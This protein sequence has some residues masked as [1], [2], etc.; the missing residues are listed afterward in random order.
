MG[1]YRPATN[2][3]TLPLLSEISQL[4]C[5]ETNCNISICT[6]SWLQPAAQSH[7]CTQLHIAII[8]LLHVLSHVKVECSLGKVIDMCYEVID[9]LLTNTRIHI[10]P[11]NIPWY[12]FSWLFIIVCTDALVESTPRQFGWKYHHN[13]ILNIYFIKTILPTSP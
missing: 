8:I 11:H 6:S 10:L 5:R 9:T 13:I 12:I 1:H 3:P 4:S 2:L 7:I